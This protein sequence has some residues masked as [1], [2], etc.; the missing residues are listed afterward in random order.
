MRTKGSTSKSQC[1][2]R[3]IDFVHYHEGVCMYATTH[4]VVFAT[5]ESCRPDADIFDSKDEAM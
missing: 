2:V 1:L 3:M 5:N 4:A